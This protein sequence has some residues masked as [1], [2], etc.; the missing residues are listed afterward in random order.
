[1][2]LEALNWLASLTCIVASVL[3]ASNISRRWSGI[4]FII[5]SVSSATWIATSMM[6]DENP[7]LV[8]NIIL[9]AVNLWGVY[10]YLVIKA[11]D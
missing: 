1:M 4:G 10:R 5:F 6:E 3:V 9:L 8:Q 11:K 2:P 7:L